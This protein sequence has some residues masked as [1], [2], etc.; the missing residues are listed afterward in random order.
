MW[1]RNQSTNS[2]LVVPPQL[3]EGGPQTHVH[4]PRRQDQLA[5]EPSPSFEYPAGTPSWTAAQTSSFLSSMPHTQAF[6]QAGLASEGS[7]TD[8]NYMDP[9]NGPQSESSH[10][11]PI[12]DWPV[13]QLGTAG[14]KQPVDP[15]RTSYSASLGHNASRTDKKLTNSDSS[16]P[17]YSGTFGSSFNQMNLLDQ[18]DLQDTGHTNKDNDTV[19]NLFQVPNN[20]PTKWCAPTSGDNSAATTNELDGPGRTWEQGTSQTQLPHGSPSLLHTRRFTNVF[21]AATTNTPP[22]PEFAHRSDK[23]SHFPAELAASLTQSLLNQPGPLSVPASSNAIFPADGLKLRKENRWENVW[24]HQNSSVNILPQTDMQQ[25]SRAAVGQ[26]LDSFS[27]AQ[28]TASKDDKRREKSSTRSPPSSARTFSAAFSDSSELNKDFGHDLTNVD[29]VAQPGL[30]AS[31]PKLTDAIG[32]ARLPS[33]GLMGPGSDRG[34]KRSRRQLTPAN[35]KPRDDDGN[36]GLGTAFT[37]AT[38]FEDSLI[39]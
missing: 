15:A 13:P 26:R 32:P 8:T 14:Y 37:R 9:W 17:G 4:S 25:A 21:N 33:E 12:S 38:C 24:V 23:G 30:D 39:E 36:Q 5:V 19:L 11:P 7:N 22:P 31:T 16:M 1:Q 20:T 2:S 18:F 29:D 34:T 35:A 10:M 3:H 28:T 27:Q 6:I